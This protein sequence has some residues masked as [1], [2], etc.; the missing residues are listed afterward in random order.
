MSSALSA[1]MI[2]DFRKNGWVKIENYL[3]PAETEALK[4]AALL[5]MENPP[6]MAPEYEKLIG[7][8]VEKRLNQRNWSNKKEKET[9]TLDVM[10]DIRLVYDEANKIIT[11]R[12][13]GEIAKSLLGSEQVRLFQ[14]TFLNKPSEKTGSKPTPWHQDS[15]LPVES[16][17]IVNVWVALVDV[18]PDMGPM[19]FLTGS[20]RLGTVPKAKFIALDDPRVGLHAEDREVV[21]D[22]V[23]VPLK[24]GDAVAFY[25]QTVHAADINASSNERMAW[26]NIWMD[27]NNVWTGMPSTSR[28][29]DVGLS[30]GRPFD[31]PLFPLIV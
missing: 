17:E 21:G 14:S 10:H 6:D 25:C 19:K 12:R 16:R 28:I 5:A 27:S 26:S 1:D 3:T 20:H 11:S 22:V 18:T 9:V 2:H 15:L 13:L 7:Y 23:S 24:A 30:I 8:R 4:N 29:D 31:H